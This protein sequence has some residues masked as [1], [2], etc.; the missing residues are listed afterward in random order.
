MSFAGPALSE[1]ANASDSSDTPRARGGRPTK[2]T[3]ELIDRAEAAMVEL[4]AVR[5]AAEAVS[6]DEAT[7]H[8]W[9]AR[10]VAGEE[11]FARFGTAIA[12]ALTEHRRRELAALQPQLEAIR[13]RAR[14]QHS[15]G[16]LP[17]F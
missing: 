7:W 16:R 6:V 10:G 8:R 17:R 11:P 4:G 3:D 2:L 9:L 5:A 1:P 14:R 12:A 13:G 15:H